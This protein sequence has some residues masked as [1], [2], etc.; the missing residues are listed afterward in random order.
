MVCVYLGPLFTGFWTGLVL[1]RSLERNDD[2]DALVGGGGKRS[3]ASSSSSSAAEADFSMS[4]PH[5]S[6]HL[7][8]LGG[9]LASVTLTGGQSV[10]MGTTMLSQLG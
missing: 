3:G 5:L 1:V 7:I 10:I 6:H 2:D 8:F 9:T 4:V